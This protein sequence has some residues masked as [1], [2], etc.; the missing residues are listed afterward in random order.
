MPLGPATSHPE[1]ILEVPL[2]QYSYIL[3]KRVVEMVKIRT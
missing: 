1:E 3:I 2:V